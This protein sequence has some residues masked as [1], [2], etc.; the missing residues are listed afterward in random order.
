MC[1]GVCV[2]VCV[3][4]C[5]CVRACVRACVCVR[6]CVEREREMRYTAD[7]C[8]SIMWIQLKPSNSTN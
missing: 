5:L 3:C 2:C 1:V 8:E 4:V 7:A 6:V